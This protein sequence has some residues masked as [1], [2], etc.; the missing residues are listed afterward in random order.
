MSTAVIQ[1]E[2]LSKRYLFKRKALMQQI[3]D[4]DIQQMKEPQQP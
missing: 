2:A 1:A 4:R 3:E